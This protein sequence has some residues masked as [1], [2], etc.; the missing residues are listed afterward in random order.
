VNWSN[1]SLSLLIIFF[2]FACR[3]DSEFPSTPEL[4]VREFSQFSQ[5]RVVWTIG[6]TDGDGDFGVRNDNDADNFILSVFSIEAGQA[7]ELPSTNYR[8]PQIR[9]VPTE[10]GVEGE[11]RLNIDDL[12]L[13]RIDNIDSLFYQGYAVDRAGNQSNTIESPRF[14]IGLN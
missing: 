6:F 7:V 5:D 8:I 11:F 12:D 13:L 9:D 10:N 14:W 3:E 1:L 2:L 4:T